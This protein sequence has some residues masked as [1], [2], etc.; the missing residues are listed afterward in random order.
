MSSQYIHRM[1]SFDFGYQ[2]WQPAAIGLAFCQLP[3]WKLARLT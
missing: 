1:N 3:T 2:H